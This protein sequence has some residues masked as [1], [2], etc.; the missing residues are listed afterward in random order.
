[1]MLGTAQFGMPY[2]IGNREGQPD[3]TRSLAMVEAAVAG[4]VNCFD[5]AA[6]Y[7]SSEEVLGRALHELGCAESVVVVT[8]VLYLSPEELADRAV[9]ERAVRASVLASRERLRIETLPIVLFHK[10]SDAVYM[11]VLE[12][13]K[14]R[15]WLRHAGVSCVRRPDPTTAGLVAAPGVSSVQ[16]AASVLDRRHRQAG[17]FRDAAS[18]GTAVFVRS[19]YLQ[20][21]L[22]MPEADIPESLRDVIPVRRPIE[23]IA[24]DAGLPV[25]ELAVR[26][27]LGQEGVTCV[28]TGVETIEQV[29]ANIA[30][31]EKGPL[32]PA[33]MRALEDMEIE[34]PERV[35]APEMWR[36][37]E[38]AEPG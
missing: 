5:T 28:L 12:D 29:R 31:C 25:S 23:A 24:A 21:L 18:N 27:M 38:D 19:V 20:G 34:L 16:L 32:D 26:Y 10:E 4:G 9:G 22:L 2:G 1:M 11:D 13:L 14:E 37:D 6:A 36:T 3:F 35:L 15:G 7:G 33:V 8:K 30:I 17:T